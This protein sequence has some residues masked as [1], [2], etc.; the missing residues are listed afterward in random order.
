MPLKKRNSEP[1]KREEATVLAVDKLYR[2]KNGV[3][4]ED[5]RNAHLLSKHPFIAEVT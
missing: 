1:S 5:W 4:R 2:G 3:L